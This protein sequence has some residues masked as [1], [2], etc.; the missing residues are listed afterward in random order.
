MARVKIELPEPV[1]FSTEIGVR[2]ADINGAGHVGNDTMLTFMQEARF[3]FYRHLGFASE[4]K[5]EGS[6]GQVVADV[7]VQYKGEVFLDDV[8]AI[9]LSIGDFN[10][11]GF[12]LYYR[13]DRKRDS[14]LVAKGKTGI[15]CFDYSTRKLSPIPEKVLAVLK[16]L[17]P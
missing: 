17:M 10:P 13:V 7:M 8:L 3:Q 14:L 6:I 9:H 15:L 2:V 5:L 12:D 1:V 11:Y 4:L 16:S